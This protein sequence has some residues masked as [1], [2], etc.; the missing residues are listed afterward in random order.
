VGVFGV[1]FYDFATPLLAPI[2]RQWIARHRLIKKDPGAAVSEPVEPIVY[3]VDPGA[4]EPIRQ[5]LV[6]G[7]SWWK[8]AFLA[9]GFA[10]A[11]RVDVLP[12][13]ADPMDLRYNMIHWVHRSTR[14][15]S[16]GNTITDPRTGEILNGRVVLD[17]QRG[18]Q[19]ALI[20]AGLVGSGDG[21][22]GCAA[23]AIPGPEYLA[24]LDPATEIT[25][26][27][28]ARIRQLS[29]HEV[30][31]TLGFAHNFAAS[32]RGRNSVMDYPSPLVKIKDG[33][34]DL[35]EAYGNEI[36]A[37]DCF[38]TR[39]AYSSFPPGA[40]ENKELAAIVRKGVADGLLFLSDAD[41]RPAGAAHP[42]ANL[43]DNGDNPAAMLRHELE[44]RRIGLD[45]FG[46]S[47][48]ADGDA[49]ADLEAKL[50]PLYLH[51]RYQLTA[52]IKLIGGVNYSYSVKDGNQAS[53]QPVVS[54]VPADAQ[55]DA[56]AAV[57]ET[58]RPETL[59]IPQRILDLIPPRAFGQ[60]T[61]VAEL[62][63]KATAPLFDPLAAS[64][65]AADLAVSGLLQ[66][67][68]ASRLNEFHAREPR[69]PN[70]AEVVASLIE[71]VWKAAPDRDGRAK[72]V[73]RAEQT[74][75]VE[76]LIELGENDSASPDVRSVASG[77]L[78]R[79]ANPIHPWPGNI[80][81]GDPHRAA[82]RQEIERF[83]RRPSATDRRTPA[84]NAPPGDPIGG[85][86]R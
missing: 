68:R 76:R 37:Y 58:L 33:K 53:P 59:V 36:G 26:T 78:S 54:I 6:D 86:G 51:H 10:N 23:G 35:S 39:Y 4:P 48:I 9:A 74:L 77:A 80:P 2:E 12:A 30:G 62:F 61:G 7:A 19:D 25:S 32:A 31:H 21:R 3:Y 44:V 1:D 14:G 56:L 8:A 18:R 13:D 64:T 79:L 52:A 16:Y 84:V 65:I 67:T 17:S 5:A 24:G 57:L 11:F 34:I 50:L 73:A 42:L 49:L 41:A 85:M 47:R 28:L 63:E 20:G 70:F 60:P 15:W 38:A 66:P 75:V 82:I 55:R 46:L 40:D 72:A 22:Q 71:E 69:N 43:W 29:A 45:S 27:V 81:E 83:L